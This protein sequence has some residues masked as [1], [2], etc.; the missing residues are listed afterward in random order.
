[1][2]I[3]LTEWDFIYDARLYTAVIYDG[4]EDKVIYLAS[5]DNVNGFYI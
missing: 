3:M 5:E 4:F 2:R 1:V